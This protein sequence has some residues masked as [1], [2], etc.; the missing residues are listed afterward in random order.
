ML[1]Q[2]SIEPAEFAFERVIGENDSVYSNFIDLLYDAK[3]KVGRIVIIEGI[4][5]IGYATGFMVSNDLLLTNWHVFKTLE[6]VGN[7]VIQFNY[8]LDING[9][10]TESIS[11]K[12]STE[13]FYFS[14]KELDYCFVGVEPKSTDGQH[15]LKDVGFIQL[16][17]NMGKLGNED[18]ELLNIIH[19]PNGDFKQISIRENRFKKILATTL[20]YESDT[21]KGSSGSPVFNDQLQVVALHHMGVAKK[22]E[23]GDYLDKNGDI[24][25]IEDGSIDVS[26]IQWEANEGIRI[27]LICKHIKAQFPNNGLI[28]D[29]FRVRAT[30]R[31]PFRGAPDMENNNIQPYI[32]ETN[33][34]HLSIP[35]KVFET[36]SSLSFEISS[37]A[38]QERHTRNFPSGPRNIGEDDFLE[39]SLRLERNMNYSECNGYQSDFLGDNLLRH[40]LVLQKV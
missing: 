18:V 37:N 27:S 14:F 39:E 13:L 5:K 3:K 31:I 25:P 34:V 2:E 26:R 4:E 10:P 29:L 40:A 1:R 35:T 6:D 15:D 36:S 7:S 28:E 20:W 17:P 23:Q 24:I 32:A 38:I 12:L 30:K 21:A 9:R 22:N 33:A 11:F 19:H 16:N 8:E